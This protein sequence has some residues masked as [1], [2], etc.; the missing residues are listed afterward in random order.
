M[1]GIFTARCCIDN[2]GNMSIKSKF[3]L[4]GLCVILVCWACSNA[5]KVDR[6]FENG[7]EMIQNHIEPYRLPGQPTGIDLTPVFSIDFG[8]EAIG[9]M[10]LADATD[11]EVDEAGNLYFFFTN[12]DADVIFQFDPKGEFLRSFG[13]KGQGP[14]EIDGINHSGFDASGNLLVSDMGNRKVLLFDSD[15][16]CVNE[17]RYPANGTLFMQ[18]ENG[19]GLDVWSRPDESGS[20]LQRGY[21]ILSPAEKVIKILD[22]QTPY[23]FD[24]LGFRGIISNPLMQSRLFKDVV[25][26]VNEERGYEILRYNLD[27]DLTRIIR[28]E[29]NPV[30]ITEAEKAERSRRFEQYGD[31]VWFPEFWLPF[32]DFLLD[33]QGYIFVRTFEKEEMTSEYIFD[34][35]NPEGIFIFRQSLNIFTLGDRRLCARF[36]NGRL[37]CFQEKP[38]SFREFKCYKLKWV[39]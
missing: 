29:F 32:G 34:V 19:N 12:K 25:Y 1:T 37:Y 36:T 33:D 24:E 21:H 31:K 26:V 28:K 2:E 5:I 38:D 22:R 13:F 8:T 9:A 23:D 30:R 18:L 27:G 4:F 35:F 16:R 20:K 14:G 10:G 3:V 17:I 11:F 7:V 39:L 15:G 6:S